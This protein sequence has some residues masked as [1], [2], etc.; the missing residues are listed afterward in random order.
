MAWCT[1]NPYS[2]T[3]RPARRGQE[4][5][6]PGT[7][8]TTCHFTNL[9]RYDVGESML[10]R[11]LRDLVPEQALGNE[12]SWGSSEQLQL[13]QQSLCYHEPQVEEPRG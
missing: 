4:R 6:K 7:L 9:N 5:R 12:G 8:E 2:L 11:L 10:E 13:M 3:R 1:E